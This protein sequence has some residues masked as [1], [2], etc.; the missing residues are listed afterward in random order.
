MG[1]F[2]LFWRVGGVDG[3]VDGGFEYV[4]LVE[5]DEFDCGVYDVDCDLCEMDY[6]WLLYVLWWL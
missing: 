6:G 1:E 4:G 3:D 2:V 5:W